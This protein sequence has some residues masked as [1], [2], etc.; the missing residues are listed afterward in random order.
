[1]LQ[2]VEDFVWERDPFILHGQYHHCSYPHSTMN[3]GIS[4]FGIDLIILD[5]P[6]FSTIALKQMVDALS[7]SGRVMHICVSKLT[8]I[9]SDN[10]FSPDWHQAIIWTNAGIL[11]IWPLGTNF[12]EILIKIHTCSFKKMH[13]KMSSEKCQPCCLGLNVLNRWYFCHN[14]CH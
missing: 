9:V 1:M 8:I 11:L 5:Y 3:Q 2:V 4:R 12:S 13:S 6:S 14:I 10:G 7:H